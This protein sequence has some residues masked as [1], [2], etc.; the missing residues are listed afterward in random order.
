MPVIRRAA[1]IL[2]FWTCLRRLRAWRFAGCAAL[3]R[4]FDNSSL[5]AAVVGP[6]C[7]NASRAQ[8]RF[9]GPPP[10]EHLSLPTYAHRMN[11][12]RAIL[13]LPRTFL[14]FCRL[15]ICAFHCQRLLLAERDIAMTRRRPVNMITAPPTS[16]TFYHATW[17]APRLQLRGC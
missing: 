3:H 7:L 15:N 9:A 11:L 17:L 8:R 1:A 6:L 10:A 12:P 4:F 13:R 16:A 2:A 14:L 5:F